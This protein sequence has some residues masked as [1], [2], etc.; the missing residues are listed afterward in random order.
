MGL[1]VAV[2]PVRVLGPRVSS[3]GTPAH[4]HDPWRGAVSRAPRRP[5]SS[6]GGP[7]RRAP[8]SLGSGGGAEPVVWPL[9]EPRAGVT[10]QRALTY[11]SWRDSG[12]TVSDLGFPGSRGL[13]FTRLRGAE[14][15][16]GSPGTQPAVPV[17]ALFRTCPWSSVAPAG[18]ASGHTGGQCLP[19]RDH[20]ATLGA[21]RRGDASLG[22]VGVGRVEGWGPGCGGE[23]SGPA[24]GTAQF[25]G[26]LRDPALGCLL[27]ASEGLLRD[28]CSLWAFAVA[29]AQLGQQATQLGLSS[30]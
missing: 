1:R 4:G 22:A 16:G 9:L 20:R 14:P 3:A 30:L 28:G 18:P 15:G 2:S 29:S 27:V 25:S 13:S 7:S 26:R 11:T 10:A 17:T 5:L 24:E 6:G 19:G 21:P 23:G 8:C 12:V